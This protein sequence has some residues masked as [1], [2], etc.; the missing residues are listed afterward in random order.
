MTTI[1]QQR[2]QGVAGGNPPVDALPGLWQ[3]VVA[4]DLNGRPVEAGQRLMPNATGRWKWEYGKVG[5]EGAG[6]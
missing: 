5:G 6:G 1:W 2:W 4:V 3:A